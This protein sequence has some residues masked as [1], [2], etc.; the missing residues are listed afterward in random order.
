MLWEF[1]RENLE[2]NIFVRYFVRLF[3]FR[4][5][6]VGLYYILF[7]YII[8]FVNLGFSGCYDNK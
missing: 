2:G 7:N 5:R 3:S 4:I 6:L 8:I 1:L